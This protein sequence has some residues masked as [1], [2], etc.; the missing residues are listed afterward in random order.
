MWHTKTNQWPMCA[1]EQNECEMLIREHWTMSLFSFDFRVITKIIVIINRTCRW[2]ERICVNTSFDRFVRVY[3]NTV[4]QCTQRRQQS[5]N[6]ENTNTDGQ[7]TKTH[8]AGENEWK[9]WINTEFWNKQNK[10]KPTWN[11]GRRKNVYK[12]LVSDMILLE[13]FGIRYSCFFW[14]SVMSYDAPH[15]WIQKPMEYTWKNT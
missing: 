1:W 6:S 15:E 3:F 11:R 5:L 2:S 8:A 12:Y 14:L 9:F 13:T 7:L 10:T 4:H